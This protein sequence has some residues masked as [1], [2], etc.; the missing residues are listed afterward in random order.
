MW[1]P[2]C[3]SEDNYEGYPPAQGGPENAFLNKPSSLLYVAFLIEAAKLTPKVEFYG[4][5]R[6]NKNWAMRD[7]IRYCK[8][9]GLLIKLGGEAIWWGY[10]GRPRLLHDP[11]W[12]TGNPLSLRLPPPPLGQMK[13]LLEKAIFQSK[14]HS[15]R[16]NWMAEWKETVARVVRTFVK[17]M[18][19]L[20]PP[21]LSLRR[22]FYKSPFPLLSCWKRASG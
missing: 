9:M 11:S 12:L 15:K 18:M 4:R 22:L 2:L 20:A 8:R 17:K 6:C 7:L 14:S 1:R 16:M 19:E 13:R 3:F 5:E 21:T 10:L